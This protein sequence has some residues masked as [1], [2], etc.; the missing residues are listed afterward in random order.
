MSCDFIQTQDGFIA[1]FTD[2]FTP[3]P[4]CSSVFTTVCQVVAEF[5][6]VAQFVICSHFIGTSFSVVKVCLI[7]FNI[8]IDSVCP[9]KFVQQCQEFFR[10]LFIVYDIIELT[11]RFESLI[12]VLC[13]F[14][15]DF[16]N[17]LEIDVFQR[18]WA[19][20]VVFIIRWVCFCLGSAFLWVNCCNLHFRNISI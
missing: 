3:S 17:T 16:A 2:C 20:F 9:T 10:K 1:L 13:D 18:C 14:L 7:E 4:I 5:G 6:V 15:F 12:L 11:C 8:S 19:V